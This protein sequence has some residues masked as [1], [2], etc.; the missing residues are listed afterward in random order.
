MATVVR[1]ICSLPFRAATWVAEEI[2]SA[3]LQ[4]SNRT[5][6]LDPKSKH[7]TVH[8]LRILCFPFW[9]LIPHLAVGRHL[10][11]PLAIGYFEGPGVCAGPAVPG[12]GLQSLVLLECKVYVKRQGA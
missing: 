3:D 2:S 4:A 8:S 9:D 5:G 6:G 7:C 11:P 12:P 10:E 1:C